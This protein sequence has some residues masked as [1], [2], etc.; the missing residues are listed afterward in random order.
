MKKTIKVRIG[1]PSERILV[2]ATVVVCRHP[3]KKYDDYAKFKESHITTFNLRNG[4]GGEK[5]WNETYG[6]YDKLPVIK[7][8]DLILNGREDKSG[9][10]VAVKLLDINAQWKSGRKIYDDSGLFCRVDLKKPIPSSVIV[11]EDVEK[12]YRK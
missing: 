7:S 11:E 12:Q 6:K 4:K 8:G 9:G 10:K 5:D 1:Q 2:P 3:E